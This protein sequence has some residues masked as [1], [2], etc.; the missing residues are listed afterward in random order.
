MTAASSLV[1]STIA[2]LLLSH[3][4]LSR[5][6]LL[7][8]LV[9]LVYLMHLQIFY[10][11]KLAREFWLSTYLRD[12]SP[13]KGFLKTTK[14]LRVLSIVISIPL[15]I[16]TYIVTYAYDFI[17]C[18][19]VSVSIV[20]AA[21][22]HAKLSRPLDANVAERLSELTHVRVFYWLA[23]V[24]VLMSLAVV[25]VAKGFSD[26]Y[27]T[28]TSGDIATQTIDGIKHPVV[29]VRHCVRTLRYFELQ[30]LR[31]RDL[32]GWPYGWLIYFFFLIPN[33]L[34]AYGLVT[35]YCGIHRHV[36][37]ASRP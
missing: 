7:S 19:A 33:A 29:I 20:A 32:N 23:I 8:V 26:D 22:V 17:D 36:I 3:V 16:A 30:M 10:M 24:F 18:I 14:W 6:L 5:Y 12:K 2:I 21:T 27:S 35:L 34:P 4:P 15:A 13:I 37:G 31:I 28:A 11:R 9:V 25:S 1:A